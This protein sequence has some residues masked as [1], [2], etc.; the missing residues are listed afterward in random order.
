MTREE[1]LNMLAG[2][3]MDALVAEKVM[4]WKYRPRFP[5]DT[6][7]YYGEYITEELPSFSTDIAAAWEVVK[8]I[9]ISTNYHSFR[10]ETVFEDRLWRFWIGADRIQ[11]ESPW[12]PVEVG[13]TYW[14]NADANQP[15][16]AICRAALLVKLAML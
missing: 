13:E 6:T 12:P 1:I 4:K 16:L 14:I 3:E 8:Y 10:L 9:Q 2:R 5:G 15:S 7:G 11:R